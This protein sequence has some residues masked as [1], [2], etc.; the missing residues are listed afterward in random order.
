MDTQE[1]KLLDMISKKQDKEKALLT[2]VNIMVACLTQPGLLE[3][4]NLSCLLEF[5]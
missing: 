1:T 3:E 4:Q 5:A 2:A